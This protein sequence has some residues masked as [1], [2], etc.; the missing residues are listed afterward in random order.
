LRSRIV[1]PGRTPGMARSGLAGVPPHPPA[2]SSLRPTARHAAGAAPGRP[3]RRVGPTA[4][5]EQHGAARRGAAWPGRVSCCWVA[6][7]RLPDLPAGLWFCSADPGGGRPG[8]MPYCSVVVRWR[9]GRIS[10]QDSSPFVGCSVALLRLRRD[11]LGRMWMLC[12]SVWFGAAAASPRRNPDRMYGL[13]CSVAL[14]LGEVLQD[15]SGSGAARLLRQSVRHSAPP[16]P[17]NR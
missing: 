11:Q 8:R 9:P 12:C 14:L 4:Q 10:R 5:S 1:S 15:G 13:S 3:G 7:R 6:A 2:A 17:Q 16:P